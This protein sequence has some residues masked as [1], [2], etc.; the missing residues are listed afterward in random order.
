MYPGNSDIY[1]YIYTIGING[2]N[3]EIMGSTLSASD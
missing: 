3:D 1:I 2:T